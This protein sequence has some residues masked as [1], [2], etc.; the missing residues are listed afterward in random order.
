MTYYPGKLVVFEG[1]DQ[2]GKTSV[3][4]ELPR[5]LIHVGCKVPIVICGEKE[6]PLAPLLCGEA[7]KV[8]SAFIKTISSLRIELGHMKRYV[9]QLCNVVNW[10]Y[11]IDMLI[12]PW[13]TGQWISHST[14]PRLIWISSK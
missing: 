7:L 2:A 10:C 8:T 6:S 13:F 3:I 11:G 4:K 9:F 1:I 12:Q 5:L 14:N